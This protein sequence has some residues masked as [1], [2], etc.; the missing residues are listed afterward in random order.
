VRDG[1][2]LAFDLKLPGDGS[3]RYPLLFTYDGYDAGSNADASFAAEYLPKGYALLGVNVRGTG[4]SGGTFDFFEPVQGRDGYD[5]IEWAAG[6]DWCTGAVGTHGASY[7][8]RIQWITAL[9]KPPSL[10][11][12]VCAVA[13]SDP[14]VEDPSGTPG[15]MHLNWFRLVDARM[16]QFR[17]DLDWMAVYRHR[18]LA[19]MDEAAG[20][21]SGNWREQLRHPT[22]DEWWEPV[23]YQHRIAEIDVPVLHISGWY[24][25][26][27]IGTPLNFSQLTAA[28]RTHQR[29]LMGPWG[30]A[31]NTTRTLGE[32][33]FGPDAIIDLDAYVI[34]FFDEH[35]KGRQPGSPQPPVRMFVM[36][37]NEWRNEQQWPPG[38]A[39]SYVWHLS[40]GGRANSRYG[41]GHLVDSPAAADEQPDTW[42]HDPDRPV[43]FITDA[44]SAQIGGPDDYAGVESRGDVLVYT[45]E[46]L[47]EPLELIGP[48][49]LHAFVETDARDTDVMAKLIDLHPNGFAQRLCDGMTRLRYRDGFDQIRLPTPGE[50]YEV[51]VVMWDTCVRVPAGHC[52]RLEVA[53]SA[54]PKYDVNLGTG[55]DQATET[56]GVIAHNRLWH[57]ADRPS[58]LTVN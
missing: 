30:H 8:G 13:P 11:A 19:T 49:R 35:L 28:G 14:F 12:M 53:S 2:L 16:P 10:K 54:F 47:T 52:V 25:D 48:V 58:R 46:P 34:T 21:I 56:A 41:D 33:D 9:E 31:I 26:E 23:R 32:V 38:T 50:V 37:A 44:S 40:S 18:P 22:L 36:G 24:D 27:E 5:A 4:C 1:T 55:G 45:S 51:E 42:T 17:D 7:G 29:L 43:P 39:A 6:Q 57:S 15:P 20:F 3:G